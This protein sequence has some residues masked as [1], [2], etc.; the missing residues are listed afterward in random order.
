ML[1]RM[2]KDS[3]QYGDTRIAVRKN[4]TVERIQYLL[5]GY[6]IILEA[7]LKANHGHSIYTFTKKGISNFETNIH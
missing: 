3:Q 6:T 4:N 7:F 1:G 5:K 2:D